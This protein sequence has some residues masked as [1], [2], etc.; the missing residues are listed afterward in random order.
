M[1]EVIIRAFKRTDLQKEKLAK[2]I[3]ED[4]CDIFNVTGENVRIYFEDRIKSNYFK[5][6]I[7]AS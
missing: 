5:N 2:K 6:G 7:R 4:I 1:P 3:T